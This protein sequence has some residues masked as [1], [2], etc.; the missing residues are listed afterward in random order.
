MSTP[1]QHECV[2][3]ALSSEPSWWLKDGR[4]IE[5]CRV[6]DRCEAEKLKRYRPEI[7]E[8]YTENDVVEQIE[9]DDW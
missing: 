2:G 1:R 9:P 3:G 7:L 8:H 6:C 4:G 5:L